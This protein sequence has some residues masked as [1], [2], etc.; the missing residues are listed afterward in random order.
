MAMVVSGNVE[1]TVKFVVIYYVG[2]K[3]VLT[4]NIDGNGRL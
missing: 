3:D 2:C 4:T 1:K